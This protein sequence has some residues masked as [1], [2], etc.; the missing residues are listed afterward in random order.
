MKKT[1]TLLATSLFALYGCGGGGGSSSGSTDG[2]KGPNN[3]VDYP[4]ASSEFAPKS[5][6]T[7]G[8]SFTTDGQ[9]EGLMTMNFTPVSGELI[10][11]GLKEEAGNEEVVQVI[12]DL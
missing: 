7:L 1:M 4:I 8:Y 3:Q 11:A 12:N 2:N 10:I 6:T 9:T 5:E